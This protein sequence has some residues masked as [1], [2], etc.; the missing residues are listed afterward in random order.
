MNVDEVQVTEFSELV[1]MPK[2]IGTRNSIKLHAAAEI[3]TGAGFGSVK[4]S[5]KDSEIMDSI[6]VKARVYSASGV[7]S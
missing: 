7:E 2:D 5:G 4:V 3:T 6:Y 1:M